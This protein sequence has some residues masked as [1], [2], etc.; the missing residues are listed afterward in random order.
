MSPRMG[1]GPGA[2]SRWSSAQAA[3]PWADPVGWLVTDVQGLMFLPL[4]VLTR[5]D[6]ALMGGDT[7][8]LPS[9]GS[10]GMVSLGMAP[11][12]RC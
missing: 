2:P 11:G 12:C 9:G 10:L 8:V 4:V 6:P 7:A 3:L 5:V 1:L